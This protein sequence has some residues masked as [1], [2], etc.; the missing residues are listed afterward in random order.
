[1]IH[2][3]VIYKYCIIISVSQSINQSIMSTIYLTNTQCHIMN[4]QVLGIPIE[5]GIED[6]AHILNIWGSVNTMDEAWESKIN[7][8][9]Q[10]EY[11]LYGFE[12]HKEQGRQ[13]SE[14]MIEALYSGIS[15]STNVE[16]VG[17]IWIRVSHEPISNVRH[18]VLLQMVSN[19]RTQLE[20]RD[21]EI[22]NLQQGQLHINQISNIIEDDEADDDAANEIEFWKNE[23]KFLITCSDVDWAGY[24][25]PVALGFDETEEYNLQPCLREHIN[26]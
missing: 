1:M 22:S 13:W 17:Q 14:P 12:F 6:I 23:L 4:I 26:L 10:S 20:A 11:T 16:N 19:M 2:F 8:M 5:M 9:G 7:P 15:I 24:M 18:W 21:D 25:P 3:G